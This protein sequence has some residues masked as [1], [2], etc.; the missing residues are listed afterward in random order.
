MQLSQ[1]QLRQHREHTF[2]TGRGMR[3]TSKEQAV[4]FV[5]ERGFV[6]FWPIKGLP[7]PSLWVA[8]AGDRP[9]PDQH[10]DPGHVTWGWKDSLLGKKQWYYGRVLRKR[11]MMISL[12]VL[13]Y[14]YAL[15]PNYGDLNEDYLIEYESGQL[16]LAS[17]LIYETLLREGPQDTIALRK[18][19]GLAN[20][21]ADNEFNRALEGLQTSFRILPVGVSDAGAWHYSFIYD[22]VARH[23]PDLV[24]RAHPIADHEARQKLLLLYLQ[25]VGAASFKEIQRIFGTSPMNWESARTQ[26]DLSKMEDRGE[27]AQGVEMEGSKEPFVAA[28]EILS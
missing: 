7:M 12:D 15:S 5:N 16:P 23:F 18:N 4:D 27:A 24:E 2:R 9:V 17:K 11:N 22:I 26:R 21:S 13:P 3:I 28:R 14:F 10:D 6:F 19:A 25:S 20:R 1:H 8:N